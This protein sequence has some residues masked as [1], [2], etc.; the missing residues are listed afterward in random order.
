MQMMSNGKN[1]R[2]TNTRF[3]SLRMKSDQLRRLRV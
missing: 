3:T 2:E 1:R